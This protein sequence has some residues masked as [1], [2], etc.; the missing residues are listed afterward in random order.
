[1][2][3]FLKVFTYLLP[4]II[5]LS[6]TLLLRPVLSSMPASQWQVIEWMPLFI[7]IASMGLCI[8][9]NRSRMF[10][11][12]LAVTIGYVFLQW[13]LPQ[14]GE[15]TARIS[16]GV[17]AISLPVLLLIFIVIKEK[18]IFTLRGSTRFALFLVP[19]VVAFSFSYFELY[20]SGGLVFYQFTSHQIFTLTPIPQVALIVIAVS[21]FLLNGYLF[22][23]PGPQP[24]AFLGVL[25]CS[26]VLLHDYQHQAAALLFCSTAGLLLVTAVIQESYSMAY[27][28][29][30]TGL[31]GRRALN[32]ELQKLGSKYTLAMV[33]IDHFKKFNDTYGHD[34]GDQVL[35]KIAAQLANVGMGGKAF[36]LGGEEFCLVFAGKLIGLVSEEM[37][38]LCKSISNS[39]FALR[40]MDKAGKN[41]KMQ[42][43]FVTVSIGIAEREEGVAKPWSVVKASDQA[44]YRAKSKG[45][46]RVSI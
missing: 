19:V 40:K 18:G 27:L 12:A 6:I 20:K 11:M 10:F 42:R 33:D 23:S 37:E 3:I 4:T 16:Y 14:L 28:D 41:G 45:R 17:F 36:R 22:M 7:F 39:R 43:L 8:R 38:K 30:L 26:V 46:N 2:R 9:F 15:F 32:E 34:V 5:L 29:E 31:P 24:A 21:G 35:R 25:I 1:M 44:L 13:V